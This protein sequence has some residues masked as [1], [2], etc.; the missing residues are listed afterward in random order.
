MASDLLGIGSSGL[1]AQQKML[2]T[3]S[4]NISN[5]STQGYSRQN[6][7]VYSNENTLGVGNSY[8]RRLIDTY[9]QS[10]VW[11]DTATYNQANTTY[12]ELSQLDKYL[13]NSATSLS[14]SIDSFFTA[15]QSA[16]T[17]P[18]TTSA[19]QGLM[20][21]IST[22]TDRFQSVSSQLTQQ[23]DDI[24]GKISTDLSSVNS[25]LKSISDLNDKI[26]KTYGTA[27]D[28]TRENLLDQRDQMIKQLSEKIDIRTVNQS[29]GTTLVNLNTG[30]SLV[31]A[32][33]YAQLSSIA[34]NPDPKNTGIQV[35][36]GS[37]TFTLNNKTLG[38]TL[39]GYFT[40]RDTITET[41]REI[42]QLA[43]SFTD[44]MNTQNSLGMTLNNTLGGNLF[45]IAA[46]AGLPSSTNTGIGSVT[47]SVISGQGSKVPP[48]DFKVV[49]NGASY[50]VYMIDVSSGAAT[51]LTSM[52]PAKTLADYGL[53]LSPST[54]PATLAVGDSFLLQ[55]ARGAAGSIT[56]VI[57]DSSD[58][59]LASP[60]KISAAASNAGSAILSIASFT[61]TSSFS[62]GTPTTLNS[63]A[64]A[65]IKMTA[66]G[67]YTVY[68]S[69]GTS[70]GT[71]SSATN[72]LKNLSPTALDSTA[73]FDISLSGAAQIGD[74]FTLSF[75]KNGFAD[76]SNGLKLAALQ[77]TD[78]VRKGASDATDNK[79]TFN[80][81][82]T[83][84]LTAV[85]TT[86]NGLN[87]SVTAANTKLTQ[88]Q[89]MYDSVAGVNLDEEAANLV[90]FQQAYAASAK[91][92]SAAKDVFDTLL[93]AVK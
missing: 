44:A 72:I 60:L 49:N 32:G 8:T 67:V 90:R 35:S 65:S 10:E 42:G 4:N 14:D 27:D 46:S 33:G 26:V 20:G 29:N 79:M 34:G 81:A 50:D 57:T 86:V 59:A 78:L 11:R 9:A 31:L 28:G 25:T 3:T 48:N 80:E 82:F 58:L 74:Q 45:N 21:Q 71:S 55:P 84:T 83:T 91:V 6:T 1:L 51:N 89:E 40:V 7:L 56:T 17:S 12:T 87:T 19:R 76:N 93:S 15:M 54:P 43:L 88:S 53:Q 37:A 24:N 2:S 85:G 38:G 75:N 63:S 64:P 13:S 66:A 23:N 92:I 22:I 41:Q 77:T 30:E 16:N 5:V 70:L 47:M 39:G 61:S 52:T 18:N 73:G 69:S 68:D 36:Q 62:S